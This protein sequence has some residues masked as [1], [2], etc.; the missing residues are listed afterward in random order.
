MARLIDL[1]TFS[2][3]AGD[4]VGCKGPH[5]FYIRSRPRKPRTT[6]TAKQ[7]E[8]RA[9]L[10]LVMGFLKPLKAII[11][12]GFSVR[13]T[14]KTKVS[15]MNAAASHA[16]NH[17]ITGEYPDL[18]IDPAM[19][20][21][22]RGML[23]GLPRAEAK[24][25]GTSVAATWSAEMPQFNGHADDC[26][27]IV[28]YNPAE[29]TVMAGE[30]KREVGIVSVDVSDEPPGSELLVYACVADRDRKQF[31]NSQFLGRLVR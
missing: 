7:L 4:V 23:V 18:D 30:A 1:L 5:G 27:T 17:A 13:Y 15:A 20:R 19:V 10:A 8:V 31:S 6:P 28:V 11:Y 24:L 21:L 25:S 9:R 22:S 2:G 16:L 3:A 14:A 12:P 29:K 26:A